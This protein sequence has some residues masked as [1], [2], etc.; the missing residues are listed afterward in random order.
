MTEKKIVTQEKKSV[1]PD[2]FVKGILTKLG[3]IVDKFTGRNWQPSSSLATGE[4]INR[5]K[6]ILDSEARDTGGK[7]IFVPHNIKLK[8]Q[9][10]KFSTDE[11]SAL[12]KLQDELT[13]AAI[14]HIND[15]RYHTYK[16]LKVEVKT[17]YFTEGVKFS[18]SFDEFAENFDEAEKD[19]VEINV[20]VPQMKAEE[21]IP[22]EILSEPEAEIFAAEFTVGGKPK[23]V[24]LKFTPG[25]RI[26]VGRTR[27]NG[28][29]IE[30]KEIS[31]VHAT[32][33][34]NPQNKLLVA[35]T[36]STN[37][38]FINDGRIAYG[39]AFEVGEGDKLRFG[40]I[41]VYLRRIPKQADFQTADN[42][43]AN[44]ALTENY[45]LPPVRE[46]GRETSEAVPVFKT[47]P[48]NPVQDNLEKTF[49]GDTPENSENKS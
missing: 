29:A 24:E 23:T 19:G 27:E 31:K 5:M 6:A 1:S 37:G 22:Q 40:G 16:P 8:M 11:E 21:I 30:D 28:L 47:V 39:R 35:D 26:S 10:D 18:A 41:E 17:D 46:G 12:K 49:I 2:W 4:L 25:K 45:N 43:D 36:G 44:T 7:G 3:D 9:W 33:F 20:T 14:D 48:E 42:Y 15:N 38:T 13:I 34:L 32:L